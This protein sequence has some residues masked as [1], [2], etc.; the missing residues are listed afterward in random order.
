MP[1]ELTS[2]Q[3][4]GLRTLSLAREAMLFG[5]SRS[6][7]TFLIIAAII[8]RALKAPGS[9]HA[10][11]RF[12][13]N[14][15]R[16]SIIADTWP[17][18]LDVAFPGLASKFR[19]NKS[20]WYARLEDNGAEVW[21]GGLDDKDRTE[22]ILGQE[23]ATIYLNEASQ[24]PNT[25]RLLALTRLA[26]KCEFTDKDGTK[27]LLPLRMWY[28]CNPP[29]DSHWSHALF[30]K[31]IDPETRKGIDRSQYAS[32]Q[33]NP[34][35]DVANLPPDYIRTLE[36]M[37]ARMRKRFL[38][39]Q[40]GN[41]QE[42]ALWTLELLDRCRVDEMPDLQRVVVAVDPSGAD[43]KDNVENDEIGI[44]VAGLGIDGRAY[45]LEDAT[46]KAGPAT[47]GRVVGAAYDR[48]AAD[49]VCGEENFGGAMVK[50]TIQVGRPGTPYKKVTASRGKVLRAEPISALYEEG[51][52]RHV[53][54]FPHLEDEM[55]AMTTHGF[56]GGRSPNR[57]DALVIALTE[58]FPAVTR[59]VRPARKYQPSENVYRGEAA[60]MA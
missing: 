36:S 25:S 60:W 18:V 8:M 27:Q 48:H 58:L 22:K 17:K 49:T 43:D 37:P 11:M 20:D 47:W 19:L 39:G 55:C 57:V 1:F 32:L 5:G 12:A 38:D 51:K 56:T 4:E 45:V 29:S 21:F 33:M 24:I 41:S 42:G 26:Q 50:H 2:R 54:G 3:M 53:G 6:G 52:V 14:H 30:V 7:K 16:S 15:L 10:V 31:G 44:V 28:D 13:F 9:R 40:F 34:R 35:D 23:H 59:I 46:L